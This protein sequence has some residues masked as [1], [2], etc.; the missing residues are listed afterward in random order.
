V[1]QGVL[2]NESGL[3]L[4]DEA[5]VGLDGFQH[6]WRIVPC[7]G[8]LMWANSLLAPARDRADGAWSGRRKQ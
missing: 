6:G 8:R 7:S 1:K 3:L 5:A 2:T 4:E